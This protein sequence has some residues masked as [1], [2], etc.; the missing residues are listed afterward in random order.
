MFI[1]EN[2]T[3]NFSYKKTY[4]HLDDRAAP[5]M[6]ENLPI[7]LSGTSQNLYPIILYNPTYYSQIILLNNAQKYS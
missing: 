4:N 3:L 6:L 1:Q 2:L 7:I 5:I